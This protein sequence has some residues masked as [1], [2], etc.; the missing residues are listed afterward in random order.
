M[1]F[2]SFVDQLVSLRISFLD[3]AIG[4]AARHRA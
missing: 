3:V 2:D 4:R 1:P